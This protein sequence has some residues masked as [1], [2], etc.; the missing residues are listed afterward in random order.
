MVILGFILTIIML[1]FAEG[2]NSG[3]LQPR[4]CQDS[5]CHRYEQITKET[6]V[7][8]KWTGHNWVIDK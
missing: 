5:I 2:A 1:F 6:G 3:A 4:F 7:E 8:F